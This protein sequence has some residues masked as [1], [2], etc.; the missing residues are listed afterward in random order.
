MAFF[1]TR[2]KVNGVGRVALFGFGQ[3]QAGNPCDAYTYGTVDSIQARSRAGSHGW[4]PVIT[5]SH[6]VRM[7]AVRLGLLLRMDSVSA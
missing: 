7:M 3:V 1:S 2:R 6:M 4:I 5:Y